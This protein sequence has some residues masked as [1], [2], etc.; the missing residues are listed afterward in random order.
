MFSLVVPRMISA[1]NRT[2][3]VVVGRTVQIH[4][5]S[6]GVPNP[7]TVIFKENK[8]AVL[9]NVSLSN[10]YTIPNAGFQDGGI[11]TCI[12][13][14]IVGR[15]KIYIQVKVLSKHASFEFKWY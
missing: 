4:C 2:I 9:E 1:S 7:T 8:N 3:T 6:F 11:Y 10:T 13:E 12:A 5:N 15:D 14:N